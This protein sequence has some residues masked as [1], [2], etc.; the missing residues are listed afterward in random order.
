MPDSQAFVRTSQMQVL[1]VRSVSLPI[2]VKG[3][4]PEK[5]SKP[6]PVGALPALHWAN[7]VCHL[8][9]G[10]LEPWYNVLWAT[11]S[12][13]KFL[14]EQPASEFHRRLQFCMMAR[15]DARFEP[16]ANSVYAALN[17]WQLAEENKL[18]VAE[19]GQFG[20]AERWWAFLARPDLVGNVLSDLFCIKYM[21]Q[22]TCTRSA[23]PGNTK[24]PNPSL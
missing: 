1:P 9:Q 20:S 4:D 13:G 2:P 11:H 12:F 10:A 19:F 3:V 16:T 7:M 15:Y 21:D 22:S 8:L 14:S 6:V 5:L 24:V 18:Q 23:C 17:L